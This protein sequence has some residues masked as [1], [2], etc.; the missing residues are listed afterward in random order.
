M[1]ISPGKLLIT[2]MSFT[3]N[4]HTLT[5][6]KK[7]KFHPPLSALVSVKKGAIVPNFFAIVPNT[8][9]RILYCPIWDHILLSR[10]IGEEISLIS[11]EICRKTNI[12][13]QRKLISSSVCFCAPQARN[14]DHFWVYCKV[15]S[16]CKRAFSM[17]FWRRFKVK[18]VLAEYENTKI[19]ACGGQIVKIFQNV[20]KK[21][22]SKGI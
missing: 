19:S 3:P 11:V 2:K 20:S 1:L 13:R 18:N 5:L 9:F 14:F 12:Y 16:P 15:I 8:D 10:G 17:Y 7:W 4:I 22:F 21:R 6:S